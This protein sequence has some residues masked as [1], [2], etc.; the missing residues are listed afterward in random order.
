MTAANESMDYR[1]TGLTVGGLTL[2]DDEVEGAIFDCDG[3]LIDSMGAWLP[4]WQHTCEKYGLEMTEGRFWGFAGVPLPDIVAGVYGDKHDG[5]AP[6]AEFV[7]EFLAE[8]RAFHNSQEASTGAP[9]AI[10]C[11]IKLVHEYKQ[12][13]IK[14]AVASSGLR[15]I[16]ERHCEH[17]GI[18]GLFDAV[19]VAAEVPK[20]KPSPDVFLK[21]A[22]LIGAN[23]VKC[24]AYEDG[25]SGIESAWRAGMQVMDVR[26][27]EGYPLSEGLQVAMADQ[28]SQRTWLP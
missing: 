5:A 4:S 22:E 2:A 11:V 20:G 23:P 13:G 3:T 24:R 8:K 6:S 16:V 17:A 9:P 1:R 28:R 25:E 19:V 15:D 7:A 14:V 26:E 27:M 21:A 18:L 10:A 12:R